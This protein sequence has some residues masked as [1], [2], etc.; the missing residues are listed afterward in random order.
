MLRDL[1]L[2]RNVLKYVFACVCVCLCECKK[3]PEVKT[4]L[5]VS[6]YAFEVERGF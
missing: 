5:H 1:E 6:V 3:R 4:D 2:D